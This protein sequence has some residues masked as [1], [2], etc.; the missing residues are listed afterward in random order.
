[1]Y[2]LN[3]EKERGIERIQ[4][5]T[6]KDALIRLGDEY[7]IIDKTLARAE[8]FWSDVL[9]PKAY[10]NMKDIHNAAFCKNV[11]RWD[12]FED[13]FLHFIISKMDITNTKI[14]KLSIF[15]LIK[16]LFSELSC[17]DSPGYQGNE[18]WICETIYHPLQ[19]ESHSLTYTGPVI[20]K[21]SWINFIKNGKL[22]DLL[23]ETAKSGLR[24]EEKKQENLRLAK[25]QSIMPVEDGLYKYA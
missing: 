15:R 2:R 21:K 12:I 10:K 1:M 7:K 14:K 22:K 23:V 25:L 20:H 11:L 9:L 18:S 3:P 8:K 19:T 17:C 24:E 5:N 16:N 13:N 6:Q 4:L